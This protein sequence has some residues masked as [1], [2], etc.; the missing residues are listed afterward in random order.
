MT[1]A[2]KLKKEGIIKR[3]IEIAKNMLNAGME[4]EEIM[5]I[6]EMEEEKIKLL[7]EEIKH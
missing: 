1:I 4:I 5:K 7:K 3:N 2:E 6:T